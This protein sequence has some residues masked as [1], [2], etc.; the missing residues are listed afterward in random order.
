M[1]VMRRGRSRANRQRLDTSRLEMDDIVL[2]LNRE[3][4]EQLTNWM[5]DFV[6]N[7]DSLAFSY[8]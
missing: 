5:S 8:L 4:R 2:I 6:R 7:R 1:E 3:V